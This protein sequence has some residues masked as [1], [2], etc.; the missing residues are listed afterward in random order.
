MLWNPAVE[1][2]PTAPPVASAFPS[3]TY[4]PNIWDK[5][6][7]RHHDQAIQHRP[8]V[9]SPDSGSFFEPLPPPEIPA[10]L[11][12]QGHYRHVTGE[13]DLGSSPSP[14]RMKVKPLFP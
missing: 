2:P 7:S 12:Q 14:D 8:S 3:D 11:L 6:I 5:P 10:Q 9:H 13:S 1:P 4:F